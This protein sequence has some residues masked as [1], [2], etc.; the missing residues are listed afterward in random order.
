[1]K[2]W[3]AYFC[4]AF[5]LFGLA[6][7]T[8]APDKT[9]GAPATEEMT[10]DIGP[11]H[12]VRIKSGFSDDEVTIT[13]EEF[14][15]EIT[16]N[17]NSLR[18]EKAS[19]TEGAT[20][21][22]YRLTWLDAAEKQIATVTITDE[23]GRQISAEGDYYSTAPGL[24]IRMDLI[25]ARYSR[26]FSSPASTDTANI[27]I[28]YADGMPLADTL[29]EFMDYPSEYQ[30]KVVFTTDIPVKDFRFLSLTWVDID[31]S[32]VLEFETEDLYTWEELSPQRPIVVG[33]TF[34]GS[35]PDRGIAY[36]DADGTTKYYSIGMSG[37]GSE[38]EAEP[39]V[40]LEILPVA[41]EQ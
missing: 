11:A 13:D 36:V 26:A 3:V 16:E 5:L 40:L 15:Q 27:G 4:M 28:A 17:M 1:M 9:A 30:V 19:A 32:G 8:K 31:E 20:G 7:C 35:I 37:Q 33:M 39:L 25:A 6:G 24:S 34:G 18:F 14:I 29:D 22:V 10:F 38:E 41:R 23:E 21:F 12:E 2:K